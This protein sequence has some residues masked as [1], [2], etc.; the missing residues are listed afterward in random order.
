[1]GA[2][3]DGGSGL[4]DLVTDADEGTGDSSGPAEESDE[5]GGGL[6]PEAVRF[7]YSVG[8]SALKDGE[9]ADGV[10]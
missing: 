9:T 1:M 8:V 5:L 4:G 10:A 6:V 2:A 3:G 7:E